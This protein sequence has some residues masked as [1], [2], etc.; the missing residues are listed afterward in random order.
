MQLQSSSWAVP[1][2]LKGYWPNRA[3]SSSGS[4]NY[5]GYFPFVTGGISNGP[6]AAA[7]PLLLLILRL[8]PPA[9]VEFPFS[10]WVLKPIHRVRS[11]SSVSFSAQWIVERKTT[12]SLSVPIS[13]VNFAFQLRD[14]I[15]GKSKFIFFFLFI[16]CGSVMAKVSLF[17]R[18]EICFTKINNKCERS[19]KTPLCVFTCIFFSSKIKEKGD[20]LLWRHT[21]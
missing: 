9:P 13:L 11:V 14:F 3:L 16:F 6:P 8:P 17:T 10:S 12:T 18:E 2:Q 19:R 20:Q 4:G 1:L 15:L 5:N 7:P 21:L